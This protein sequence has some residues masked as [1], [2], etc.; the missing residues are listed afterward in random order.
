MTAIHLDW[1]T[2]KINR[3]EVSVALDDSSR[4]ILAEDEFDAATDENSI[5]IVENVLNEYG[6][7]GSSRSVL[8]NGQ[9][10]II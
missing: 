8:M 1:N 4:Y 5:A 7:I 2:N 6:W 10:S 3:K 9:I